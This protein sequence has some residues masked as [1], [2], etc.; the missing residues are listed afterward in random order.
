MSIDP[1]VAIIRGDG[2]GADVTDAALEVVNA[3]L[4]QSGRTTFCLR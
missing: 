3:A 2:I 1:R 4:Q